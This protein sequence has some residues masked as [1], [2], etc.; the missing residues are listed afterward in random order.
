[1]E[2]SSR[3]DSYL[4]ILE[5]PC[6]CCSCKILKDDLSGENNFWFKKKKKSVRKRRERKIPTDAEQKMFPKTAC[7]GIR[8]LRSVRRDDKHWELCSGSEVSSS[9]CCT[10]PELRSRTG[11]NWDC[12]WGESFSPSSSSPLVS[13]NT[14]ETEQTFSLELRLWCQQQRE[15]QEVVTLSGGAFPRQRR[16]TGGSSAP[17]WTNAASTASVCRIRNQPFFTKLLSDKVTKRPLLLEYVL[18]LGRKIMPLEVL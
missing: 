14:T 4:V 6:L 5:S 2:K 9:R 18:L 17:L 16:Q 3:L 15:L 1:M 11:A 7:S 13:T 10:N 12:V 8:K